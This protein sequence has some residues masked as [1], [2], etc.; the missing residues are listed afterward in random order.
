MNKIQAIKN[1]FKIDKTLVKEYKNWYWLIRPK[2][3]TLGSGILLSKHNKSNFSDLNQ[4][5]FSELKTIISEIEA[6]LKR[7]IS[8]DKINY[9]MLMM[10]DPIVHYHIIPRHESARLMSRI[11]VR[12]H[13]YPGPPKLEKYHSLNEDEILELKQMILN[14]LQ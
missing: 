12:D 1:K 3:V 4:D 8:Y 7:M 5:S 2:Q 14:N 9:L 11:R 6:T 13:G 10:E